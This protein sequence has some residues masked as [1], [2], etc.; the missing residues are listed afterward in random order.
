MKVRIFI[1]R[2]FISKLN[3]ILQR[4]F[5]K[6]YNLITV[7]YDWFVF[8]VNIVLFLESVQDTLETLI[9]VLKIQ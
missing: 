8:H 4:V 5:G 6:L 2:L 1:L 3:G 7:Y 9:Q